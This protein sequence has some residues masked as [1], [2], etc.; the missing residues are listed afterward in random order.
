MKKILLALLVGV[1]LA[2]T[3]DKA[4]I[5]QLIFNSTLTTAYGSDGFFSG[6]AWSDDGKTLCITCKNGKVTAVKVFHSNGKVA[7]EGNSI[8]AVGTTYDDNGERIALQKFVG[9]YPDVVRQVQTIAST[10][11]YGEG[12]K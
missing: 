11:Q 1:C 6:E 7:I 2:C 10:I 4:R 12:L 3:E 5:S 8:T 9:K